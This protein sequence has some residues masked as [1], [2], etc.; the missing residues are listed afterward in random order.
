LILVDDYQASRTL[1]PAEQDWLNAF[2]NGWHVPGVRTVDQSE[3]FANRYDLHLIRNSDLAPFLRLRN[4]PDLLARS[5]RFLGN[6][7]PIK[8]AILPSMLGSMALQQCLHAKIIEYRFLVFEK[9]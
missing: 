8:H 2:I 5:L 1:L 3:T 9:K 6:V 7:I 4:L